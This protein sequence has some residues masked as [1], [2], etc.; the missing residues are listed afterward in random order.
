MR[1]L[2]PTWTRLACIN[3]TIS[4][5][6]L[7]YKSIDKLLNYIDLFTFIFKVSLKQ[8]ISF[9]F[10]YKKPDCWNNVVLSFLL[11]FNIKKYK[12]LV[13]IHVEMGARWMFMNPIRYGV[14]VLFFTLVGIQDE[15]MKIAKHIALRNAKDKIPFHLT[16]LSCLIVDMSISKVIAN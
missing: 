16:T 6:L 10:F 8:V 2:I 9:T 4:L 3:N 1:T 11:I 13:Q 15:Y 14:G 12:N 7:S 5:P